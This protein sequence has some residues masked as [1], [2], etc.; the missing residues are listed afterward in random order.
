MIRNN[1]LALGVVGLGLVAIGL[2][3]LYCWCK[4]LKDSK[5]NSKEEC[6]GELDGKEYF[7]REA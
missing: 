4:S 7:V 5:K 2:G 3:E 1:K 6:I